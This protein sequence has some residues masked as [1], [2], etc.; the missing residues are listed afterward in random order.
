VIISP[1]TTLLA[2]GPADLDAAM[3]KQALGLDESIRLGVDNV[4]MVR[5]RD[6]ACTCDWWVG[7]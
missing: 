5:K 3:V 1:L 6:E 4:Y 7:E 2:Y